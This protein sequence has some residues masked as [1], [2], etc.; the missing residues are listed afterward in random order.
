MCT[1][2]RYSTRTCTFVTALACALAWF[3]IFIL[4]L[5]HSHVHFR[6]STRSCTYRVLCFR[7]SRV[8]DIHPFVTAEFWI[9]IL[10]LQHSIVHLQSFGSSFRHSTHLCTYTVLDLHPFISALTHTFVQKFRIL[11]ESDLSILQCGIRS[12]V[13]LITSTT[14]N[15]HMFDHE[16]VKCHRYNKHSFWPSSRYNSVPNLVSFVQLHYGCLLGTSHQLSINFLELSNFQR[17]VNR[18]LS[19]SMLRAFLA[20]VPSWHKVL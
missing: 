10:S 15:L 9:F 12:T 16:W 18:L 5:Q 3:W 6:Q 14:V 2:V 4:S 19:T 8:L 1:Y 20:T 11:V 13:C 7:Y 17:L